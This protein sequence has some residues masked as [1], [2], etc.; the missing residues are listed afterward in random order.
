M[1]ENKKQ[2]LERLSV[3][4][5]VVAIF[6]YFFQFPFHFLSVLLVPCVFGYILLQIPN[7]YLLKNK[8]YLV[9]FTAFI[10]F[11]AISFVSSL[12]VGNSLGR[13]L[14]FSMIIFL[15]PTCCLIHDS[16]TKIK[17]MFFVNFA[18]IKALILLGFMIYLLIRGDYTALRQWVSAHDMGDIYMLSRWNAKVQVHGNSLLL[19]AFMLALKFI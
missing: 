3:I 2:S 10:L 19:V 5:W 6:A 17:W 7:F 4:C 11:V 8:A 16:K 18:T 14:R 12:I 13:V 9:L 15:L 1:L